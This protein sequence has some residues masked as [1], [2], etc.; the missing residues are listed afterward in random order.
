MLPPSVARTNSVVML[1]AQAPLRASA[2]SRLAGERSRTATASALTT[3]EKRGIV[4]RTRRVDHDVFEPNRDGLYYPMALQTALVD[5]PIREALKGDRAYAAYVFGSMARP[6][7]ATPQSDLDLLVIGRIKDPKRTNARLQ[8]LGD[9]LG[10]RIDSWFLTPEE[11]RTLEAR[12]DAR[13]SQALDGVRVLG[14]WE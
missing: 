12:G 7:A 10:R 14:S 3:L 6:G 9:R 11:A 4:R 1:H 8:D 2:I 5:L 13:L